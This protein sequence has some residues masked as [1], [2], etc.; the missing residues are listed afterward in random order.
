MAQT[1][2]NPINSKTVYP[3]T[4]GYTSDGIVRSHLVY[5]TASEFIPFGAFVVLE[6][7]LIRLPNNVNDVLLGV[8]ILDDQYTTQ[9]VFDF[10]Y[11][12]YEIGQ[13]VSV[14]TQGF[15]DIGMAKAS[16]FNPF[17]VFDNVYVGYSGSSKGLVSNVSG[18]NFK[19][20][21]NWQ[22][23]YTTKSILPQKQD[24]DEIINFNGSVIISPT[25]LNIPENSSQTISFSLSEAPTANVT[26]TVVSN[27]VSIATVIGS[28]LT[29][30]TSNWGTIQTITVIAATSVLSNVST[31][32]TVTVT[33]SDPNWNT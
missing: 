6:N 16:T 10:N 12:G 22:W 3:G 26:I 20:V 28:P 1:S 29:F 14:Y 18:A 2:I 25:T 21:P 33:S 23:R 11:S 8:A 27:N 13:R 30:T 5:F 19:F 17:G 24:S 15:A 31:T 4:F 7:N 32:L 9:S